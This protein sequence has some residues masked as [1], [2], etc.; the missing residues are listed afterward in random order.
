MKMIKKLLSCVREYRKLAILTFSLMVGESAI[1]CLI[2]FITARLVNQIKAG[3]EMETVVK[4]GVILVIMAVVSLG[5]GAGAG[6]TG[7]RASAGFARNL[8]GDLF[9]KIQ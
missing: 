7:A 4:L 3:V 6:I 5:C 1:E 8:R 2:P 9:R